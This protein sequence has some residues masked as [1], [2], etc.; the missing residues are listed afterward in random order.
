MLE[1]YEEQLGRVPYVTLP[2]VKEY[3]TISSATNDVRLSNII[4]YATSV[5]EHYIG[6]EIVANNYTELFDGGTNSVYVSRLPLNNVYSIV[7]FNGAEYH[8]LNDPAT[9]GT[10]I[11]LYQTS[12]D[13]NFYNE[14]YITAKTKN[15]GV[16]SLYVGANGYLRSSSIPEDLQ[17]END[18]FTIEMLIRSDS[19]AI[20]DAEI[21]AI[22][23]PT[24]YMNICLVPST[25]LSVNIYKD[26]NLTSITSANVNIESSLYTK[27]RWH[28]IAM[29]RNSDLDSISLYFNG[30]Q[31]ANAEYDT[32][33]L[34]FTSYVEIGK[35]FTGYIDELRI[36]SIPRYSSD[37]A[38]DTYRFRPDSATVS[39]FH[40]DGSHKTTS[41]VDN[42]GLPP[43]Y[44]FSIATGQI[45]RDVGNR[46][47]RRTFRAINRNQNALNLA[48]PPTFYPYPNGV[49]VDYRAGYELNEVPLDLQL[50]TLDYV[51]LLHK[52]DQDR[53]RVSLEG[54]RSDA[55][56]LAANFPP[57]IVR[58][59]DL[60]RIIR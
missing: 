40:F 39:L 33:N 44:V 57:H 5:I 18:D 56:P 43:D 28:H 23:S 3:L 45:M 8:V 46:N 11:P 1:H 47:V 7:E 35:G 19:P 15:Y 24:E 54:E 31:I 30:T 37:F 12:V 10:P 55:T 2:Q 13:F 17:F 42:R 59:L 4:S 50:A 51:K 29:V 53:A 60:Y 34:T 52:Q 27:R 26:S 25:G 58:I 14:A 48:G 9:D 49:R 22:K 36:S 20:P 6:Q 16:S 21:F 38:L 41:T 32:S